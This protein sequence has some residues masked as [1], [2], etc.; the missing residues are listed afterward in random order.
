MEH[1]SVNRMKKLLPLLLFL[2]IKLEVNAQFNSGYVLKNDVL[3]LHAEDTILNP[4]SG[5]MNNPQISS[6]DLNLDGFT[7]LFIFE[8]DGGL[9]RGF[10][11]NSATGNYHWDSMAHTSFPKPEG[12][13]MLLRDYNADG[14]YD[15]FMQPITAAGFDV[16]KNVSD[17]SL[18]FIKAGSNL[19]YKRK[20]ASKLYFIIPYNDLPAISDMDGDGDLDVIFQTSGGALQNSNVLFYIQNLSMETYGVPDSLTF[21]LKNECWG[22]ISEYVVDAGWIA[23]DCSDTANQIQ[24]ANGMQ[25]RDSERHGATTITTFDLNGDQTNDILVGDSYVGSMIAFYNTSTNNLTAEVNLNNVD[26]NF[27]GNEMPIN[28]PSLAAAHMVDA[29]HD[30][31][32]DILVAPNQPTY[33]QAEPDTSLNINVDWFYKNIGS[34]DTPNF[35]L[36]KKGFLGS[37]MIDVG[38]RSYPTLVDLTGDGLLDLVI[39][40]EGFKIYGG[41]SSAYL[42]Y[43]KNIGTAS[44]PVFQLVTDDFAHIKTHG[45]GFAHPTF[46]DLDGDGDQDMLI[47]DDQGMLHYY[48]NIGSTN[49]P[50]F[51]LV[52]SNFQ[53]IDVGLGAHPQL[54]DLSTDGVLDL[55]V[56]DYYGRI[57]YF[58]NSGTSAQFNFSPTP[59]ILKLGGLFLDEFGGEATPYFT[60]GTDSTEQLYAFV[61]TANGTILAY[62]PINNILSPLVAIDSILLEAKFTSIAGGNLAGDLR[63]ELIIGQRTGGL[64]YLQRDK[65]A[66][67]A[68]DDFNTSHASLFSI[69]PNPTSGK[70]SVLAKHETNNCP[71][72]IKLMDISGKTLIYQN[73]K[74]SNGYLNET[75]S[76]GAFP[77]GLYILELE[78]NGNKEWHRI[79]KE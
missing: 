32:I 33:M 46:G 36:V 45:Y 5:G 15:I 24:G 62:G 60:K 75:I 11:Y 57:Q 65:N 64:F 21:M 67:L 59:N 43:Y 78:L 30:G 77:A 74:T 55:I 39:G 6:V 19:M 27:P 9:R 22:A 16:Y 56:G 31:R 20:N 23:I 7:D 10:V 14:K 66:I 37:G 29:D 38:S 26:V 13:F 61:G 18:T 52:Q 40:N 44:N 47:G 41:S 70:I 48:Q 71:A 58:E 69:Y 73:S 3:V 1:P 63:D 25:G 68:I 42:T 17:T 53:G 72:T 2:F 4:W 34:I 8:K 54:F 35:T 12:G 50:Q 49:F 79:V 28:T 51:M 76:L